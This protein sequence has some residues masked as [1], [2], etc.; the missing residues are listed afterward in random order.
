MSALVVA[1][2]YGAVELKRAAHGYMFVALTLSILIHFSVIGS[3]YFSAALGDGVLH[4]PVDGGGVVVITNFPFPP[5]RGIVE[6]PRPKGTT[7]PKPAD[8]GTPVPVQDA[9]EILE[10]T[11]ASQ[12]ELGELVDPHG[13][14][15]GMG[16]ARIPTDVV[17]PEEAPRDTFLSVER[18]PVVV[19]SAVPEYPPLALKAG[20]EGK[21]FVKMWVD[22]SG[23]VR[24]VKVAKSSSTIF[25]DAAVEAAK[26]FVFTPAYM[27]NGP[28][29]V[30][31]A[32]PF[33]FKLTDSK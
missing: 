33:R 6:L 30:W 26:Q 8:A 1:H 16:E 12:S 19:K 5:I 13:V 7:L 22:R 10:K 20:I 24:E 4:P 3:Y 29:S 27:T 31:V 15:L 2:S 28:V 25:N 9:P 23:K 21:V 18:E 14:D 17:I 32:F 11:I